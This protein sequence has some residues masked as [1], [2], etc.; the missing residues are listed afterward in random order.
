MLTFLLMRCVQSKSGLGA[1]HP[2]P[3]A[4]LN[5]S[6]KADLYMPSH[7]VMSSSSGAPT[8]RWFWQCVVTG[9]ERYHLV[10]LAAAKAEKKNQFLPCACADDQ[11]LDHVL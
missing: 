8:G 1:F 9:A 2:K 5:S 6:E 4:S 11:K 7:L 10:S 3:S